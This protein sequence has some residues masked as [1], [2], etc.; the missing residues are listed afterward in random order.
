M[1]VI[2]CD[3]LSLTNEKTPE[4]VLLCVL[5]KGRKYKPSS[6]YYVFTLQLKFSIRLR[7]KKL[8]PTYHIFFHQLRSV[9]NVEFPT[10]S[11]HSWSH[12]SEPI[13]HYKSHLLTSLCLLVLPRKRTDCKMFC[14]DS[15]NI[16]L[17][18]H[19]SCFTSPYFSISFSFPAL[20]SSRNYFRGFRS[21]LT[22][23]N[24]H[25]SCAFLNSIGFYSVVL[26]LAIIIVLFPRWLLVC[27]SYSLRE[28]SRNI[29]EKGSCCGALFISAKVSFCYTA[30][31][32]LTNSSGPIKTWL[33]S[34]TTSVLY[35]IGAIMCLVIL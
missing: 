25:I 34:Q 26:V 29:L 31:A 14:L 8:F 17:I 27:A 35:I 18:L 13:S 22:F 5:V 15:S 3:T 9:F 6:A 12:L 1:S 16:A 30:P 24:G 11:L 33:G 4:L 32:L 7:T 23:L 10:N 19:E 21:L 20:S 2:S 28:V